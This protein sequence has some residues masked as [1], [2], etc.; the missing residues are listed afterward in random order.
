MKK[1]FIA[2]GLILVSC[3]CLL[4][5]GI[6]TVL[7]TTQREVDAGLFV[8]FTAE[9]VDGSVTMYYRIGGSGDWVKNGDTIV[10]NAEDNDNQAKTTD[11]TLD[12]EVTKSSKYVEFK[13]EFVNT[14]SKYYTATMMLETTE[15]ENISLTYKYNDP[16]E[17]KEYDDF[18]YAVVVPGETDASNAKTYF[19]KVG[20]EDLSR[21]AN[22]SGTFNWILK[23]YNLVNNE[24]LVL[25]NLDYVE[26]S[27]A[28]TYSA[29]YNGSPLEDNTL[30]I[31]SQIG[32]SPVTTVGKCEGTLP[33]DTKVVVSEGI[34]SISS[35]AFQHQTG[36]T[37][38]QMPATL[39]A[40]DIDAFS[41]C[42]NLKSITFPENSE[43]KEIKRSA[44][45][46]TALENIQLP[47]SLE[48]LEIQAFY[49]SKIESITIPASVTT[50]GEGVFGASLKSIEIAEGNTNFKMIG[51]C[52]IDIVNHVLIKGFNN[53]IIPNDGSIKTIG[54][55]A[56]DY[57]DE[58]SC[59]FI[60]EGVERIGIYTFRGCKAVTKLSL[61][62]TLKILDSYALSFE[63]L[64]NLVLP[65]NLQQINPGALYGCFNLTSL[66]VET[67]NL[68][69]EMK[70]DC[71]IEIGK[72]RIIKGLSNATIP[73]DEEI[74]FVEN[75]A[76]YGQTFENFIVPDNITKLGGY[77]FANCKNLKTITLSKNMEYIDSFTF[78]SC[79]KLET[80]NITENIKAIYP[81]AFD[82]CANL[83]NVIFEDYNW[84][85]STTLNGE[86]E[87]IPSN[88]DLTD[89]S[90]CGTLLKSTY[91]NYYWKHS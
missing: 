51:N 67:G 69:F 64:Q 87:D 58:F 5:V 36:L 43:L 16:T 1:K 85:V 53:S 42:T 46:D 39:T 59:E 21:S 27:T 12:S 18:K 65:K 40:I 22:F 26:T 61:P 79:E 91:A 70:N 14:G 82:R 60:P 44:F 75:F 31:P 35:K 34:T 17:T 2:Y 84:Q 41:G 9:D 48:D 55:F 10:F 28:G 88:Y 47:E 56:F 13:Y 62:S 25:T 76:F 71:L 77:A 30:V 74:C 3:L 73:T 78:V 11:L 66:S 86:Y 68:Y 72:G 32:D 29:K 89:T 8:R 80:V 23:G 6:V 38:V 20:M 90:V 83:T 19:I 49:G 81:K 45:Q 57:M 54:N 63:N 7:A 33:A 37:E 24:E 4:V 15:R 52:L 50:I